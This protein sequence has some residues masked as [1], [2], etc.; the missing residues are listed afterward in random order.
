MKSDSSPAPQLNSSSCGVVTGVTGPRGCGISGMVK[1][2]HWPFPS[3]EEFTKLVNCEYV[4]WIAG[5]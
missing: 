2:P 3:K 1:G 5:M 4:P